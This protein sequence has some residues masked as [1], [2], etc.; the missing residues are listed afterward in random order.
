MS[1]RPIISVE[2]M[3]KLYQIGQFGTGALSSDLKR[4]WYKVRGKDDPFLVMGETND[5]ATGGNSNLVWALK[6]INFDVY[7]GDVVGLVGKNGAGKSTLLKVLSKVTGPTTGAIKIKG[8]VASMLEVGTGFHP[9]L[10]GRENIFLNGTILGMTRK[11]VASKLD[12]I[13]DFAGVARYLDTPTKRYSSGMTVRLAFAVAAHLEPEILLVDEVLAVGDAEFQKKCIGKMGEVSN[14]GR[15]IVF[16]S[17]NLG[18]VKRLCKRGILLRNGQVAFQ[19]SVDETLEKYLNSNEWSDNGQQNKITYKEKESLAHFLEIGVENGHGE[20]K[21]NY[22]YGEKIQI[23]LKY[24]IRDEAR[25][26]IVGMTLKRNGETIFLTYDTDDNEE[27][28]GKRMPG[29][30]SVKINLPNF[31]K[32]GIYTVST[33]I[34]EHGNY[35]TRDEKIDAVKFTLEDFNVDTVNKSFHLDKPGI[36]KPS[37]Q[38][39]FVDYPV[40]V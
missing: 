3:S 11:E 9:E 13:V 35:I 36:I 14:E 31:L 4:W 10:T 5:R 34:K 40:T 7:E 33:I 2:D 20:S 27:L 12:S 32:A 22:R 38:W 29:E 26:L 30:Y 18:S 24:N 28:T 39:Q 6:D 1:R 23:A 25:N 21:P 19:G 16:V 37:I 8:R 17:H 15:T